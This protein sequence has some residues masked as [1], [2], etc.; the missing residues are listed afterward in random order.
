MARAYDELGRTVKPWKPLERAIKTR[1]SFRIPVPTFRRGSSHFGAVSTSSRARKIFRDAG[2]TLIICAITKLGAPRFPSYFTSSLRVLTTSLGL[3]VYKQELITAEEAVTELQ[4]APCSTTKLRRD[5]LQNFRDENMRK[6]N[7]TPRWPILSRAGQAPALTQHGFGARSGPA[8]LL[9]AQEEEPDVI[10]KERPRFTALL[11][12]HY[13]SKLRL[14]MTRPEAYTLFS[15]RGPFQSFPPSWGGA[16]RFKAMPGGGNFTKT[17]GPHFQTRLESEAGLLRQE[18]TCRQAEH[19]GKEHNKPESCRGG[20]PV[21]PEG[22][23]EGPG[24]HL[25]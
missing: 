23:T 11:A 24:P 5:R 20:F 4:M 18:W 19:T 15:H 16:P 1:E 7:T 13:W 8:V 3:D 21:L 25:P 10:M 2:E 14:T 6:E 22:R 9:P 12:E 17:K